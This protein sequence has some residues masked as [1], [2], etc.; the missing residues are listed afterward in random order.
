MEFCGKC[1]TV[2]VLHSVNFRLSITQLCA[3]TYFGI[4]LQRHFP[5][6]GSFSLVCSLCRFRKNTHL[7]ILEND[8]SGSFKDRSHIF[9]SNF[10]QERG[11]GNF[12][13]I[14][15]QINTN[16][17]VREKLVNA[18]YLFRQK[19]KLPGNSVPGSSR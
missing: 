18:L 17:R 3:N 7:Y 13:I 12:E 4:L 10:S 16:L 11:R 9:S 15:L 6:E 1:Q 8:L 19:K 5:G 14:D 2:I